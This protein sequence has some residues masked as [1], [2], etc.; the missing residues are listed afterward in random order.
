M[1]MTRTEGRPRGAVLT[2]LDLNPLL[3]QVRA[4]QEIPADHGAEFGWGPYAYGY[5]TNGRMIVVSS[6]GTGYY[7]YDGSELPLSVY[8]SSPGHMALMPKFEVYLTEAQV[9][10][11]P[12]KGQVDLADHVRV[13]GARLE[14]NFW[15]LFHTLIHLEH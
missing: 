5:A 12:T 1:T 9:L 13:F 10:A 14:A 11:L 8:V 3:D 7:V 6:E 4:R 15:Q 2:L